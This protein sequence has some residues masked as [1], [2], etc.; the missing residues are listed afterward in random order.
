[1]PS[2]PLSKRRT[3]LLELASRP[4]GVSVGPHGE[5]AASLGNMEDDG[6]L[7]RVSMD[8]VNLVWVPA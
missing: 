1:M 8:G 5:N 6:L 7:K 2:K 3:H 4:G